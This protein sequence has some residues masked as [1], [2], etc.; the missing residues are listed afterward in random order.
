MP[1]P[2]IMIPVWPVA[3]KSA[4]RPRSVISFAMASAVYFLPTAHSVPT[5]SSL[6]PPRLIPLPTGRL[7]GGLRTSISETPALSA[8]SASPGTSCSDECVP[9]T[10]S[11]PASTASKRLLVHSG[12]IIPPNPATP[13]T[14]DFAPAA[15]ASAGVISGKSRSTPHPGKRSWPTQR[16]RRQ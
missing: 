2:T 14:K 16:S 6:L 9:A 10:I 12:G 3:L 8:A 5:V 11:R 7:A 13:Q 1:L 4:L 15:A